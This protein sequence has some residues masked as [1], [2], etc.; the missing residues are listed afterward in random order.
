MA[1]IPPDERVRLAAE[2]EQ[3]VE[4]LTSRIR[5]LKE[6]ILRKNELLQGYERD[7]AKL[8]QAE[9]LA[10]QKHS[11]VESLSVNMILI[12][13]AFVYTIGEMFVNMEKHVF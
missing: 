4:Q 7:L 2:R 5:V 9:E 11:Q 8:R 13:A 6:R 3:A 1:H 12:K 10:E